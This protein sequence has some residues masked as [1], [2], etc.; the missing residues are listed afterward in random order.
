MVPH[1]YVRLD[2]VLSHQVRPRRQRAVMI[3]AMLEEMAPG[4]RAVDAGQLDA[5]CVAGLFVRRWLSL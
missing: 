1:F 5:V 2:L 4:L 3:F